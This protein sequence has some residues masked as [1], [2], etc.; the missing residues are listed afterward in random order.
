MSNLNIDVVT[1][2][3]CEVYKNRA[4]GKFAFAMPTFKRIGKFFL[5][6]ESGRYEQVGSRHTVDRA[7]SIICEICPSTPPEKRG[8]L[9][10]CRWD[11]K[12]RF[13]LGYQDM[14]AI[15]YWYRQLDKISVYPGDLTEYIQGLP[16]KWAANL[17][18][19]HQYT[20]KDRGT[21]KL[22]HYSKKMQLQPGVGSKYEGTVQMRFDQEQTEDPVFDDK[23]NLDKSKSGP[24]TKD[25]Q[26]SLPFSGPEWL[27]FMRLVDSAIPASLAWG[28]DSG[29]ATLVQRQLEM[30]DNFFE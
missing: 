21:G 26:L 3:T 22:I 8:D 15:L 18:L 29:T 10:T 6:D 9:P 5:P 12:R 27:G 1:S 4:A 23:G 11:E 30:M 16:N 25:E 14:I 20:K 19:D 17:R 28:G 7:G 13:S 24:T 2:G